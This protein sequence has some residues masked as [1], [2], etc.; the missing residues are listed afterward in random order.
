MIDAVDA[1]VETT[2]GSFYQ[3]PN[4]PEARL[5]AAVDKALGDG[6]ALSVANLDSAALVI[7]WRLVRRV[8]YAPVTEASD[9]DW[10][11]LWEV[12]CEPH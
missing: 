1:T 12:R 7:P 11:L 5:R 10:K 8:R 9:E 2:D 3:F 6:A 4:V